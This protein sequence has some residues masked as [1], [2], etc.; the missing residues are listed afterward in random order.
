[1]LPEAFRRKIFFTPQNLIYRHLVNSLVTNSIK[2]SQSHFLWFIRITFCL[3][4]ENISFS[5]KET[6]FWQ[7]KLPQ[8]HSILCPRHVNCYEMLLFLKIK[9][10]DFDARYL[11][12]TSSCLLTRFFDGLINIA[13]KVQIFAMVDINLW[14]TLTL[15]CDKVKITLYV[16]AFFCE[17]KTLSWQPLSCK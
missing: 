5:K 7:H 11:F 17:R 12:T 13:L 15:P 9:A 14:T 16:M 4:E 2:L 10:L 6:K 1:M 8:D 3:F